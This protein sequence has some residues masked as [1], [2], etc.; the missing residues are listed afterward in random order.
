MV[1]HGYPHRYMFGRAILF[2][3][4]CVFVLFYIA[5]SIVYPMVTTT[6]PFLIFFFLCYEILIQKEVKWWIDRERIACGIV[7]IEPGQMA[8]LE[9][10]KPSIRAAKF[11]PDTDLFPPQVICNECDENMITVHNH[12]KIPFLMQLGQHVGEYIVEV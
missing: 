3:I 12:S 1:A 4:T 9:L 10:N 8:R 6:F 7:T 5:F 11:E 2:A